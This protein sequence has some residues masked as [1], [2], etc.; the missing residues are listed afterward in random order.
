MGGSGDRPSRGSGGERVERIFSDL[1]KSAGTQVARTQYQ[2][3]V[4]ELFASLLAFFNNRDQEAIRSSVESILAA[5]EGAIDG[6]ISLL[7]GG[8]VAKHTFVNGLSDVDMIAYFDQ[9]EHGNKTPA[10][11]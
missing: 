9:G 4:G 6:E 8:S 5:L 2:A 10:D 1:K 11:L 3:D 7:F